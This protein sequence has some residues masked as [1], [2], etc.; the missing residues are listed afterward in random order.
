MQILKFAQ[1]GRFLGILHRILQQNPFLDFES[2]IL[3]KQ[4]RNVQ[5]TREPLNLLRILLADV[6]N[7]NS[8][9]AHSQKSLN[10]S[11]GPVLLKAESQISCFQEGAE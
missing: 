2:R 11:S 5:V 4:S 9:K 10:L 1:N 7:P 8:S 6:Q 3:V